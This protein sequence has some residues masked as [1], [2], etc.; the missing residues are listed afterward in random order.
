MWELL[1]K[2]L[3]SIAAGKAQANLGAQ[4]PHLPNAIVRVGR[5]LYSA[6]ALW[7]AGIWYSGYV[8][9]RTEPG[10]GP[11]LILPGKRV[12]GTPDRADRVPSFATSVTQSSLAVGN[13]NQLASGAAQNG[14][15]LVALGPNQL[16]VPGS[17]IPGFLWSAPNGEKQF[18]TFDRS[19][20][21]VLSSLASKIASQF[22][23]SI[24]SGYRP[25]STGSLHA[26]GL[27]FDMVGVMPSLKRAAKWASSNPAMFQEIF[28]HNE[29]SGMHLHLGFYPDAAGI[30][31]SRS[32]AMVR[33]T[34]TPQRRAGTF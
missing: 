26:S 11:Q 8:N 20:Y 7:I 16:G 15:T 3:K 13:S 2:G 31:N 17:A 23:L 19:R 22:G 10:S 21:T 5:F 34:A 25:G 29:G 28:I 30:F 24:T 1:G 6:S 14:R 18:P 32:N 33:P 4:S 27:A 12:I 9:M